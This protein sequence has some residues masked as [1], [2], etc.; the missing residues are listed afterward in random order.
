M[1]TEKKHPD[2][3]RSILVPYELPLDALDKIDQF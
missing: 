3:N 2:K 1:L